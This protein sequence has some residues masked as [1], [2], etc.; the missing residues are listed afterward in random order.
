MDCD[1]EIYDF[2]IGLGGRDI[3]PDTIYDILDKTKNP[4]EKVNWIGLE[5]DE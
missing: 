3:T 2:I 4:T 5:E 1:T